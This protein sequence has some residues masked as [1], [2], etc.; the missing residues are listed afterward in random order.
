[1]SLSETLAGYLLQRQPDETARQNARRGVWDFIA[2]CWPVLTGQVPDSGLPKLRQLYPATHPASSALLLG[3]AGHALDYDDFHAGFHGHPSTV[4][5][6]ALFAWCESRDDF[7][8]HAF[9][10]AYISGVEMAGRL[11]LAVTSQHYIAGHHNTATLG[12]LAA[13]AALARLSGATIPQTEIA[14]GIAATQASG[15][16]AQF[17]SQVKALH[18]G[19]AAERAVQ[20]VQLALAGFEG[21]QH[22]VIEAFLQTASGG[23]AQPLRLTEHWGDP[24]RITSPGL[25]FKPFPVCSGTHSAAEAARQLRSQALAQGCDLQLWLASLRRIE[26]AFP[27]GGDI[28]PSIRQPS[29]GIE[30]RFSLE[31]VTAA[32]LIYGELRLSDFAEG[33]V[34]PQIMA[35]AARV[36]RCPDLSAPPDAVDPTQRFHQITLL[37]NDGTS[38]IQRRT[39]R[40]SLADPVDVAQKLAQAF[41]NEPTAIRERLLQ[42]CTLTDSGQLQRLTITLAETLKRPHVEE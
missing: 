25:E 28:A 16:R 39:R 4:I 8:L 12:T 41:Q 24:W 21:Q 13:T 23:Q 10:D 40:Q 19:W 42:D 3:Y 31:Y 2:A 6:P 18:A 30:A 17:G 20:A 35:L 38:L 32:M 27:P 33:P 29:N 9:L 14:L 26:I 22:G 11:G 34:N 36:E 1:M 37:C 15:L 5:L 7:P